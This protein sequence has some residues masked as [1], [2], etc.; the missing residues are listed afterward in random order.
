MKLLIKLL[1]NGLAVFAMA[2]LLPDNGIAISGYWYAIIVAIVLAVLNTFLK[3]LLVLFTIPITVVTLGLF[4]L[5]IDALI[6]WLAGSLLDGFYVNGFWWALLGSLILALITS[7]LERLVYD[8][9]R[10][11]NY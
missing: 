7:V 5:V 1:L 10:R 6:L 11:N 9:E 3:P 2:A 4:L 8:E